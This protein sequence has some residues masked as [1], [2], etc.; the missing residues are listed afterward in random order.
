MKALRLMKEFVARNMKV[1][2]DE[3]FISNMLNNK[4]W[5]NGMQ[6]PP[7]KIK[8]KAV[9]EGDS[10]RAFLFGEEESLQEKSK[11]KE[12]KKKKAMEKRVKRKAKK[13][14]PQ[15]KKKEAVKPKLPAPPSV[16]SKAK[17]EGE[18]GK[19]EKK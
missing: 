7:R 11:R 10:A 1:G 2:M 18:K 12:E 16:E 14:K 13:P 19:E 5:Q 17:P 3:V 8:I 6:K 15:V 4:I 9:K